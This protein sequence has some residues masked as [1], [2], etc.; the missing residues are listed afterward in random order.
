MQYASK[1][2]LPFIDQIRGKDLTFQLGSNDDVYRNYTVKN[3]N[4]ISTSGKV[5]D[6]EFSI[7]FK[8][9]DEG[10][11]TL[12]SKHV[13]Q[14]MME[15]IQNKTIVIEGNV[16]SVMWFQKLASMIDPRKPKKN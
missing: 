9:A 8:N 3:D 4:I 5:K 6:C 2:S 7:T 14:A 13:Q 12:R 1:T 11:K 15:G 16:A 10:Y